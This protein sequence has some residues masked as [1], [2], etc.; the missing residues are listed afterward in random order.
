MKYL[1]FLM[2]FIFIHS[3]TNNQKNKVLGF[4]MENTIMYGSQVTL[5]DLPIERN[6][7]VTV[8][9]P[10]TKEIKNFRIIGLP[11]DKVEIFE[12]EYY[13]NDRVYNKPKTSKKIYTIYL[14]DPSKF[15]LLNM[16][17]SDP[18][19]QNYSMYS[20]SEDEYEDVKKLNFVDSIYILP[21]DRNEIQKGIITTPNFK[22]NNIYYFGPLK[23]PFRNTIINEEIIKIIPMYFSEDDLGKKLEDDFYFC[24]GDN[25]PEA[26]DSR[27]HGLISQ[28]SILGVVNDFTSVKSINVAH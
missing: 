4:E 28:K 20:L 19:S 1:F 5:K 22:Y 14:K 6:C 13:I 24:I 2:L 7:I 27:Y 25:F 9:M 8:K 11:G 12:G 15:K 3:C 16:Y 18:Y 23:I 21:V 10:Q 17:K 26:K